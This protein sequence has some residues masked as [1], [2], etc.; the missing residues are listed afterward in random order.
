MK[1]VQ[2]NIKSVCHLLLVHPDDFD[3]LG[4]SFEYNSTW[5][6]HSQWAFP[7]PVL[8]FSALVPS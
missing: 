6:V 8:S 5:M 7:F 4:L 3:L 1:L 2:C